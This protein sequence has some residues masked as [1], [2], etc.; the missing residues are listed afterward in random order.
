MFLFFVLAY[1]L[2]ENGCVDI[3][4]TQADMLLGEAVTAAPATD[5]TLTM[6]VTSDPADTPSTVVSSAAATVM[7]PVT[8]TCTRPWAGKR[9]ARPAS[10]ASVRQDA[11]ASVASVAQLQKQYYESML[12]MAREK[13]AA[14]MR[15]LSLQERILRKQLGEE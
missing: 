8:A 14:K 10:I 7:A 2:D 6:T 9:R 13:H 4:L 5:C 11:A 3:V 15:I 12:E 1:W